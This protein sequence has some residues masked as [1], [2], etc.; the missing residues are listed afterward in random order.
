MDVHILYAAPRH[1]I[2]MLRV[3]HRQVHFGEVPLPA[4]PDTLTLHHG[5][6]RAMAQGSY[7]EAVR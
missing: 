6:L 1:A 4:V 5:G 7:W 2:V 3:A